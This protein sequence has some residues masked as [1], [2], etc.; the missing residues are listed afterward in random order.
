MCLNPIYVPNRAKSKYGGLEFISCPCRNCPECAATSQNDYLVRSIALFNSL[1]MNYSFFFC[2]LTF[3]PADLPKVD[4]YEKIDGEWKV[5]YKQLPSFNHQLYKTFRK[6]FQQYCMDKFRQPLYMLTT[7]EYGDKHHRPHYHC[8]CAV[9]FPS[10]WHY[11]KNVIERF[12]HY[13]FTKN[14]AIARYDGIDHKRT[15][16]NC[17]KYVT[18]YTCKFERKW[19]PVYLRDKSLCTDLPPYEIEPKTFVTNGYGSALENCLTHGNYVNNSVYL[20]IRGDKNEGKE[21]SLPSYYRRRYFTSTIID[22]KD[23]FYLDDFSEIISPDFEPNLDSFPYSDKIKKKKKYVNVTHVERKNGYN[24]ILYNTF[25]KSVKQK[26]F[27]F[28]QLYKNDPLFRSFLFE[29][30][31]GNFVVFDIVKDK[32]VEDMSDC[33]LETHFPLSPLSLVHKENKEVHVLCTK[34]APSHSHCQSWAKYYLRKGAARLPFLPDGCHWLTFTTS[35]SLP[36]SNLPYEWHFIEFAQHYK[37]NLRANQY[38][39]KEDK[40][41]TWYREHNVKKCA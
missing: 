33:Y 2:T 34:P 27:E 17:I 4:V 40:D 10:D 12:W 21:Y 38:L 16:I 37:R 39:I 22:G 9:P 26:I 30:K 11:F 1:P 24:E 20:S 32:L 23:S 31:L 29:D 5:K 36:W 8:I 18:K 3:R 28:E 35:R 19:L 6:S 7:S 41:I 25:L 15:T 13:G 14:I